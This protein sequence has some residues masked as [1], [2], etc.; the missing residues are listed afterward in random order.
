[1]P[2]RASSDLDAIA[3]ARLLREQHGV[4]SWTQLVAIGASRTD[5]RRMLSRGELVV[6]HPRVYVDHSG[7]PTRRQLEWAAVLA[8]APA[9]L[10]RESALDAH[11]MTRDRS[12]TPRQDRPV[13]V[14]VDRDRRIQPPEGVRIERVSD[15]ESWVQP[16]RRPPRARFDYALLKAAG[17][18][19][20]VDAIALLSDAVHQ[21]LTTAERLV[22]VV[23][24]LPRLP[25]RALLREVLDDV[26]TGTRSVL[27]QRYLRDVERA[28]G[29]PEGERQFRQDA[30]SGAVHRD[31]R[32]GCQRTL[33]E[34]DGAFGHRDAV[35]RWADL[36]RDLDAAVD[37]HVTLRP[38]WAQVLDAC[39]LAEVVASVLQRRGWA[40]APRPC[41]HACPLGDSGV[42]GPT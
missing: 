26:R 37:D 13:H 33:V 41:R 20:E 8:C 14:L 38:G 17:D 1:M 23:D 21:G 16:H 31:V 40:G 4:V 9:A 10:H 3:L 19:T 36:Q 42:G 7:T 25:R 32:Y 29:L 28:H 22:E 27:E 5:L 39:R 11:G 30:A 18:R 15:R 6:I 12:S 35:D 2:R 24:R 34:L